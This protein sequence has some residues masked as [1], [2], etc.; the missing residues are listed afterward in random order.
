MLYALLDGER[1][2]FIR[3]QHGDVISAHVFPPDHKTEFDPQSPTASKA[4]RVTFLLPSSLLIDIPATIAN[5]PTITAP[6]KRRTALRHRRQQGVLYGVPMK[7][8]GGSDTTVRGLI[9]YTDRVL[10]AL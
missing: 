9:E 8:Y 3:D 4:V 2:L 1:G 5:L 7:G 6:S 10:G